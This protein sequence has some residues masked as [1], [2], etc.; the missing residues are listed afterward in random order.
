MNP[1]LAASLSAWDEVCFMPMA[2]VDA[3]SVT[4]VDRETRV[5][6]EV[7]KGYTPFLNGDVLVA[8]ITPCFENGKIAQA[9]LSRR[10][11]FGSTEFHVVRPR[12]DRADARYLVHFLRQ[13]RIRQQGES[14]MTGSAG[15]RRVPEHF[16]AGLTIPLPPLPEQRRIAEILDKADALR[17][18]RRAALA[19]LDIL[20]QSIFLDLFGDPATNPKGWPVATLKNCVARIQIGPFGSLLHQEDYVDDGIPLVNPKHI[21][22]GVIEIGGDETVTPE[23]FRE[24]GVYHLA[25]GDVVMGRRG[26]MGRCA[27]V[28]ADSC[29]LLCGTGSL[30]LRPDN[31][32]TTSV[33]LRAMLSSEAIK[34]RLERLSLGQTLPNLNSRIVECLE[35]PLPPVT[36]QRDFADHVL[37]SKALRGIQQNSLAWLDALFA[38]LQHRAFRGEL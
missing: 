33:F 7:S 27:I 9:R 5:Y 11:G 15:Q 29:P 4:A 34:A 16:L 23:K 36:V 37:A 3:D 13:D 1:P 31:P 2:A 30:F 25:P 10:Y 28:E 22:S 38:S 20:T 24:L 12:A 18:K 17:A 14:R 19:Q 21:Q 32:R 26:E 6:S 35:I 8:K